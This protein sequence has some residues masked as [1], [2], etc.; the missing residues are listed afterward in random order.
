[1][2]ELEKLISLIRDYNPNADFE[3]VTKAFE[4]SQIA[5]LGQKRA[6]GEPYFIHPLA[7]AM[8]LADYKMDTTS[9]IVGLLHDTV[10]DAKVSLSEI[11]KEGSGEFASEF[12]GCTKDSASKLIGGRKHNSGKTGFF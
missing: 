4:F 6:S 9:I 2:A 1:M 7:T 10:E 8:I 5:H 12:D 3:A 11:E